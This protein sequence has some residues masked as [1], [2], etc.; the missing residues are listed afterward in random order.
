MTDISDYI[1]RLRSFVRKL[2]PSPASRHGER[3]TFVYKD[4]ATTTHVFLRGTLYVAVFNLHIRDHTKGEFRD[5]TICTKTMPVEFLQNKS[6]KER[7]ALTRPRPATPAPSGSA[8]R[9][10]GNTGDP[11]TNLELIFFT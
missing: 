4:L 2:Q 5:R 9:K 11:H 1:A 10:A 6:L 7:I 3:A 8:R